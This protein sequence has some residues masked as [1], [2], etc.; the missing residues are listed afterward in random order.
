M[1]NLLKIIICKLKKKKNYVTK[2]LEL[3]TINENLKVF[4]LVSRCPFF[5]FQQSII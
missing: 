1:L 3:I 4:L 2:K 5:H